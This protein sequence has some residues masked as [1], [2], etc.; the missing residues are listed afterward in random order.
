MTSGIW[1][2]VHPLISPKIQVH[3]PTCLIGVILNLLLVGYVSR[4]PV[5]GIGTTNI[6]PPHPPFTL[7]N[8]LYT[9]NIITNLIS[10][11]KFASDNHVSIKFDPFGFFL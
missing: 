9:P 5:K 10:V 2:S 11:Q 7:K 6:P 3:F 8:V 4:I 1:I